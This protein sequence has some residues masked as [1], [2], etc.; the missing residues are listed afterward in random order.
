MEKCFIFFFIVYGV[1]AG[2]ST[3]ISVSGGLRS[4]FFRRKME[5]AQSMRHEVDGKVFVCHQS[6]HILSLLLL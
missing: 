6:R 1:S 4:Y 2:L 3:L 5:K